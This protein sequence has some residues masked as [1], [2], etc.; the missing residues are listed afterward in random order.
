MERKNVSLRG[1]GGGGSRWE[2]YHNNKYSTDYVQLSIPPLSLSLSL[3]MS[4][5]IFIFHNVVYSAIC[6]YADII[7]SLRIIIITYP[8]CYTSDIIL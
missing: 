2:K 4:F 7:P 6:L 5:S 8:W 3:S 1:G